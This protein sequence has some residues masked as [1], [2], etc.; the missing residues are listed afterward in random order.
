MALAAYRHLLR[1][2]QIAFEGDAR[3]LTAARSAA[4]KSFESNRHISADGEEAEAGID[5]A[6]EVARILRHNVVQGQE[7]S[8]G[9][10]ENYKL[11]IHKD[12]ERGDN[13]SIKKGGMGGASSI[14]GK[15]CS[16]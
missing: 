2:A 6:E 14:L 8:Q 11:R 9:G 1:S 3:L 13:E 10:D 12:I 5:H 15:C 7:A 16:S 4:R